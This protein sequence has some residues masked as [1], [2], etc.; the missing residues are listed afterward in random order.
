MLGWVLKYLQKNTL[1]LPSFPFLVVSILCFMEL[2]L[3]MVCYQAR[4]FVK[5]IVSWGQFLQR[6]CSRLDLFQRGGICSKQ[7]FTRCASGTSCHSRSSSIFAY[8]IFSTK[9]ADRYY[10]LGLLIYFSICSVALFFTGNPMFKKEPG[11]V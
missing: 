9:T 4:L 10:L 8:T 11:N 5:A 3:D 7:S 2:D 1:F 6:S